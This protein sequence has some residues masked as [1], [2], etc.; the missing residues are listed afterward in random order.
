MMADPMT[1]LKRLPPRRFL[2]KCNLGYWKERIQRCE[3]CLMKRKKTKMLRGEIAAARFA[4]L[5]SCHISTSW[6]ARLDYHAQPYG[7]RPGVL[8]M[9]SLT[10]L[11]APQPHVANVQA[12]IGKDLDN[13]PDLDS[14]YSLTRDL[15]DF[16]YQDDIDSDL[17]DRDDLPTGMI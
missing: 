15:I 1:I 12:S 13:G 2:K 16:S 5:V 9:T 6:L 3:I 4:K 17:E 10:S 11:I 7:H 14:A 8:A